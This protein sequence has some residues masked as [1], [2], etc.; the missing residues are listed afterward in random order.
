MEDPM[1]DKVDFRP[2]N[3]TLRPE[4][5]ALEAYATQAKVAPD[6]IAA[7]F[8]PRPDLDLTY[9]GGRTITS[10]NFVNCYLGGAQAW[11]AADRQHID[12]ALSHAMS[13]TDLEQV[14]GQYFSKPISSHAHKSKIVEGDVGQ[15]FFKDQAEEL[16]DRLLGEGVLGSAHPQDSVICLM[17]PPGVVLVDGNSD[18]SE[19][20][21]SPHGRTVLVDDEAVDS[22]HGLGGYHGSVH[23]NIQLEWSNAVH[24]PEG[25]NHH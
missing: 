10:L 14:I 3:V 5:P 2:L 25:P 21:E 11:D 16:V 7:G 12:S 6:A 23:A 9:R 18:G 17:L 24:G 8:N 13:D 22:K 4:S 20:E 15:K 19:Q 1:A